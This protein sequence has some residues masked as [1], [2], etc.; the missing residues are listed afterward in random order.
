MH[1]EYID[2]YRRKNDKGLV[3]VITT[4]QNLCPCDTGYFSELWQHAVTRPTPWVP[5][6]KC[7]DFF[8][9][10]INCIQYFT[11]NLNLQNIIDVI[12]IWTFFKICGHF[13]FYFKN[14]HE[15]THI[16]QLKKNSIWVFIVPPPTLIKKMYFSEAPNVENTNKNIIGIFF[17][18]VLAIHNDEQLKTL[19]LVANE[20]EII[21][22]FLCSSHVC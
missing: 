22:V 16:S 18:I 10:W 19:F 15:P 11:N 9:N 13:T 7:V 2:A 3:T 1:T 5:P 20:D 4:A 12:A 6:R 14:C 21:W 17:Y 8:Y